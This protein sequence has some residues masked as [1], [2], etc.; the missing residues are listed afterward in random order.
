MCEQEFQ[1][2]M[3]EQLKEAAA[4]EAQEAEEEAEDKEGREDFAQ[5]WVLSL[6]YF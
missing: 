3:E 5:W 1:K 2:M 4:K 6:L